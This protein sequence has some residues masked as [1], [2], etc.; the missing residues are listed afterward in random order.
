MEQYFKATG[1]TYGTSIDNGDCFYDSIAQGLPR[2]LIDTIRKHIPHQ[3]IPD[4]DLLRFVVSDQANSL[5]R[6]N[7]EHNWVHEW[8]NNHQFEL[9][10]YEQFLQGVAKNAENNA[11]VIWGRFDLEAN[12]IYDWL[13]EKQIDVRFELYEFTLLEEIIPEKEVQAIEKQRQED[14]WPPFDFVS[15]PKEGKCS[16]LFIANPPEG[17]PSKAFG[18]EQAKSIV[19]IAL[20]S[21]HFVPVIPGE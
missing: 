14:E 7:P 5:H 2:D 19:K 18:S 10:G 6:N 21:N 3:N 17:E 9:E 15:E 8:F 12:L 13:K 20:Y 16:C 1:E 11:G 4:R